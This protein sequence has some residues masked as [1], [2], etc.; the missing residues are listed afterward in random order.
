MLCSQSKYEMAVMQK[1]RRVAC[2]GA[3]FLLLRESGDLPGVTLPEE[4]Y[5]SI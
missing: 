4:S 5:V 2:P 1:K 3:L